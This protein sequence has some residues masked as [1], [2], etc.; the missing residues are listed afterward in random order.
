MA[1]N[2]QEG[3]NKIKL[4]VQY[5]NVNQEVLLLIEPML[6]NAKPLQHALYFIVSGLKITGHGNSNNNLESLCIS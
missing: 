3:S 6:H 5:E 1:Y 4:A 2:L